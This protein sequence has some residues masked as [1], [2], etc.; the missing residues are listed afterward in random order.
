MAA[1]CIDVPHCLG[2]SILQREIIRAE[3]FR[4]PLEASTL[5]LSTQHVLQITM[6]TP[7]DKLPVE[8]IRPEV[9]DGERDAE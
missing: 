1:Q 5:G 3:E 2:W 7:Q 6:I 9:H 8:Q 4:P